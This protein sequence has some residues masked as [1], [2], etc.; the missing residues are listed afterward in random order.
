MKNSIQILQD[1]ENKVGGAQGYVNH[2]RADGWALDLQMSVCSARIYFA[3]K[4]IV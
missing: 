2:K 1:V 3:K 4:W